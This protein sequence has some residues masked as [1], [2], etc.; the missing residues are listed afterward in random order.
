MTDS[1]STR[2]HA[3][4]L[5]QWGDLDEVG[6]PG[7]DD[8]ELLVRVARAHSAAGNALKTER[9][10]LRCAEI[11]PRRAALHLAQIGWFFQRSKRWARAISWYDRALETFPDYHLV[12]FR[13]GYC[14]E[15]LH[16]PREAVAA[17]RTASD[18]WDESSPIQRERSQG[19]QAQVL[20]HLARSL[21]EIGDTAGAR[22]ALSRCRRIE[23]RNDAVVKPEHLIA[24]EAATYLRD[25][26]P[27][28][29]KPLLEE[30]HR[31]DPTSA[32]VLERLAEAAEALGR[33]DE[34]EEYLKKAVGRP[35]GAVALVSLGRFLVR[36]GRLAEAATTLRQAL[37]LHPKGEVQIRI[38]IASLDRALGRPRSALDNLERLAAGRV[39]PRSRL[40]VAVHRAIA[41]IAWDHGDADRARSALADALAHDP[42]DGTVLGRLAE[43]ECDLPRP[44]RGVVDGPV[45][46]EILALLDHRPRRLRGRVASYFA[47]RGFGFIAPEDGDRSI[48]FHV[49]HAPGD[50]ADRLRD[51]ATV[52]FVVSTSQR[53]GKTQAEE[54]L[55]EDDE[56]P[57]FDRTAVGTPAEVARDRS[58]AP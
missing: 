32:V 17:L 21:R 27:A 37:D 8:L 20:F 54:I 26:N 44:R 24:S 1:H 23:S 45:A 49:S 5:R 35:K 12:L 31:I 22:E 14:L 55:F 3:D 29:A 15:R 42:E 38:E 41:E 2:E 39:A 18:G 52:S 7:W 40:A 53:T 33:D 4:V 51:G 36:R 48:F 25:G 28:A 50:G 9:F 6:G 43:I 58:D 16:R 11:Q 10:W 34:A 56:A 47:D 46:P 30:A 57:E 19:I 13:K